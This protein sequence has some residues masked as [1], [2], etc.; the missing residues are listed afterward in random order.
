MRHLYHLLMVQTLI[1][2]KKNDMYN[3]SQELSLGLILGVG[4][5][6]NFTTKGYGY[7]SQETWANF[8]GTYTHDGIIQQQTM[9]LD[10]NLSVS[11]IIGA[12]LNMS[13]PFTYKR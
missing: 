5:G 4:I 6:Q 3:I 2:W 9:A 8:L 1:I 10:F 7:E 13:I 11:A 12:S